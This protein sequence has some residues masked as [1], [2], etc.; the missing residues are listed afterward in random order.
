MSKGVNGVEETFYLNVDK[1]G[2]PSVELG[3]ETLYVTIIH[4]CI[5]SL[6]TELHITRCNTVQLMSQYL[7]QIQFHSWFLLIVESICTKSNT[8][9]YFKKLN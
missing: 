4:H 2:V 8:I 3:T 7:F 9:F 1:R 6:Y 5:T